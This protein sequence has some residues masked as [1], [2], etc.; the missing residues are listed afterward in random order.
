MHVV[1]GTH[2]REGDGADDVATVGPLPRCHPP[3]ELVGEAVPVCAVHGARAPQPVLPP[4][5]ARDVSLQLRVQVRLLRS[6]LGTLADKPERVGLG[7]HGGGTVHV[8][9]E[10]DVLRGVMEGQHYDAGV[11][12]C[13]H[14]Q[15]P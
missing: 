9:E 6:P 7:A 5:G 15:S 12:C 8:R 2:L 10:V 4:N 3:V 14:A 13:R 11:L 1:Q